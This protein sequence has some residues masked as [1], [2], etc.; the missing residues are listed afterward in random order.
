V[1]F[2]IIV[3]AGELSLEVA[4]LLLSNG[5]EVA[6]VDRDNARCSYAK[7][8]PIYVYRGD[9]VSPELMDKVGIER[10]EIF[11]ALT[12]DDEINLASCRIAKSRGVPIVI[13][14]INDSEKLGEFNELGIQA[15]MV[16]KA[17]LPNI[18]KLVKPE[19]KQV[20][21]VDD[22]LYVGY[23]T[24]TLKSPYIG[25]TVRDLEDECGVAIPYIIRDESVV[26]ATE[27]LQLEALDVLLIVG[28]PA[29]AQ[30]C[31]EDIY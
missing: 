10:A 22:K 17:L 28:P 1:R 27:D 6:I 11:M 12:N 5:Y 31:L 3:G 29:N 25:R 4:R 15:V 8:L 2:A 26:R 20:L 21:H 19:F 13:S 9:P 23:S 24:V 18:I 7:K 14:L 16:N 30:R